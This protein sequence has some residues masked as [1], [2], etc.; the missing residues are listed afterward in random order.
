[1][2]DQK[3]PRSFHVVAKPIGSTCNLHCAYCYYRYKETAGRISDE[4]LEKFIR[5][6]IA[7]QEE[8][9]VVF[10]WHGGEPALL[11]LDFFHQVV[12][13]EQQYAQGH[14]IENDFQTNGVLLDESWCE[15]FKEQG[16][17]VGLSIDG[18]KPLHD[19][20]RMVNGGAGSF[21]QV[22]RAA[23]L[24][25]QYEIPFNPLVVV[26]RLNAQH[27]QKVYRFL[28]EELGCRR[29]QWLPCVG[30]TDFHK[31]APGHWHPDRMPAIGTHGAKPGN[32]L[33]NDWSVD[34]DDWGEFLCQTFSLWL[35][36]GL[37]K[38]LVNWFETLVGIY[39]GLPAQMCT[40]APVC[41]RSLVTLEHDGGLYSCDHFVYPEYR[42]GNLND[43]DCQLADVV[44]SPQ[45][46]RFGMN[47]RNLLPDQ[48][49]RCQYNFACNGECPKNRFLKTPDGQPGLN[50]LCSGIKRFLTYADPYLR[51]IVATLHGSGTAQA[52]A[53]APVRTRQ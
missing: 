53:Q 49:K 21:D 52:G 17:Y 44:Y 27:P 36:T 31:S 43:E 47:K 4:L 7:G 16:F 11:G 29:L 40:L 15:F 12:A 33:V 20:F 28:T 25:R 2:T 3:Y 23:T 26:H 37:G 50:Y 38:V 51:Q 22:Y 48:C 34:A 35:A 46:R 18:P 8:D 9:P 39:M 19:H 24:L 30:H 45:Q 6:Y 1:M 32:G 5:Q 13:L 14:R 41:G 10:N 42:L